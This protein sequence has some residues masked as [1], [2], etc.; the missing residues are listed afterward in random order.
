MVQHLLP[1]EQP[2]KTAPSCFSPNREP[3]SP[4]TLCEIFHDQ[5]RYPLIK[6]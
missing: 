4:A 3:Y 6:V 2:F 5:P 1:D